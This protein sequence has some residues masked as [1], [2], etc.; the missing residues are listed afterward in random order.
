MMKLHIKE[1]GISNS[2]LRVLWCLLLRDWHVLM[3]NITGNMI[4]TAIWIGIVIFI[5]HYVMPVLGLPS[6]Y[7]KFMLAGGI[8][9]QMLFQAMTDVSDVV[10]DLTGNKEVSYTLALPLPS[11]MAFTRYALTTG[12]RGLLMGLFAFPVA[13][14]VMR[15]GFF[16]PQASVFKIGLLYIV[17]SLFFGFFSVCVTSF[18]PS[19]R[20]YENVWLRVTFPLWMLGSYAYSWNV[21]HKAAPWFSYVALLNPFT[22]AMEGARAAVLGQYGFLNYW[23]CLFALIGSTVAVAYVGIANMKKRLDTL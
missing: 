22:Y 6:A 14:A 12:I 20:Q 11:W 15:K 17:L 9:V 1:F 5:N 7:S 3:Q 19:M 13:A 16:F 23:V 2:S 8:V 4:N 18:T 10:R 21:L